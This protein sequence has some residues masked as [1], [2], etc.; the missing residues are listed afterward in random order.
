MLNHNAIRKMN[1]FIG[2]FEARTRLGQL[3][4]EVK[5]GEYYHIIE[6]KGKPVAVLLNME[7]FEEYLKFIEEKADA[8]V[9][10]KLYNN[11]R[12]REL[13]KIGTVSDL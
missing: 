6:R 2:A 7:E 13:G 11:Q 4:D 10:T 3:L 12:E 1:K 8:K 5:K 9:N